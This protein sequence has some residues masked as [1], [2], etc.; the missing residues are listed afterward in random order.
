MCHFT[1][2]YVVLDHPVKWFRNYHFLLWMSKQSKS[3]FLFANGSKT[4]L[5]QFGL[6]LFQDLCF[7]S[8]WICKKK[9]SWSLRPWFEL[10]LWNW[11]EKDHAISFTKQAIFLL[12]SGHGF[13]YNQGDSTMFHKGNFLKHTPD[14]KNLKI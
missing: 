4:S 12:T 1:I 3:N 14:S 8:L 11:R 9:S 13:P 7:S 6:F 10:K 2:V 5:S